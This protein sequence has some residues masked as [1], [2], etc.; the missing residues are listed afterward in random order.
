MNPISAIFGAGVT[1]RNALYDRRVFKVHKLARPVISVGNISVG[2]TG[3]TPFVIALGELLNR[4]GIAFDVLSR[5]YGRS[6][7]EIAVVD[8]DGTSASFGDEP[9]LMA[10][11]LGVPVIVGA[12]R[13]QA[14][15]LAE[16]QFSSKLHLLDDGFQHR[17]LHR[18]FDIVLL[19]AKDYRGTLLP[20][21]RLREPLKALR[22]ADAVVL[23]DSLKLSPG[24]KRVWNVHRKTE[25]AESSDRVIAFCGIGR[26]QQFFDALQAHGQEVGGTMIFRDH[27][28]YVESD[29]SRLLETKKKLNASGFITTA[30]DVI[31]LDRLATQLVPLQTASLRIELES[32][33]QVISEILQTLEQRCACKF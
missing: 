22:R 12:D 17:R 27:H 5:G 32:P 13:Y 2:G 25:I 30:K 11:K 3:K 21:G 24:P 19:P 9:L 7:T 6:S 28:H 15:L 1:I 4:R 14:G 26:P 10:R 18:D 33:E 20:V 8:P 29:I 23:Q 31:N 16:K